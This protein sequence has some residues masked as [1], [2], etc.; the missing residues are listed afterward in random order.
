L[1]GYAS[2]NPA[3]KATGLRLANKNDF[4]V[5]SKFSVIIMPENFNQYPF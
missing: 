4:S 2:R 1:N 3:A 5:P